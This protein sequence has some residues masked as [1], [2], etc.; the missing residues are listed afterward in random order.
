MLCGGG[1]LWRGGLP[2]LGCEATLN[3]LTAVPQSECVCL[4]CD[5]FAAE[6]GQ[7][8]SPQKPSHHRPASSPQGIAQAANFFCRSL[9]LPR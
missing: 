9:V 2:P 8:P 3:P 5:C 7:A 6:R 1:L 4:F